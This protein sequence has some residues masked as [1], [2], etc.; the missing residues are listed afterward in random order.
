MKK[1]FFYYGI[2]ALIVFEILTDYLI[3]PLPG[4]Q[5]LNS[6]G[7]AYVLYH[8]R[9]IF[10]ILIAAFIVAGISRAF[11]KN[12]WLP[13]LL[14]LLTGFVVYTTNVK[15]T[16][17]AMFHQPEQ[18]AFA[19]ENESILPGDALVIGVEN[20]GEA[21]AYPIRYLAY[22]HQVQDVVGGK[23][24]LITYCNV[25]HSGYVFEPVVNGHAET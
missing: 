18:L 11:A 13:P 17:E 4:S 9:W 7:I 5:E 21:K 14:L 19:K 6:L 10:R 25:C 12:K 2:L 22:H 23:K 20:N 3:I 1:S 16:A 15:M 24:L 8:Y